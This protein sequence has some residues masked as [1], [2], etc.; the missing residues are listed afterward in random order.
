MEIGAV[1]DAGRHTSQEGIAIAGAN[2]QCG[3]ELWNSRYIRDDLQPGGAL[4]AAAHGDY[5]LDVGPD[6]VER[7]YIVADA[8]SHALQ[9]GAEE[10]PTAMS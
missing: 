9:Q 2:C 8:I 7:L 4:G 5:S 6:R 1:Q 3:H 10:V